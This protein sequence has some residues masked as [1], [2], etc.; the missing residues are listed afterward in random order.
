VRVRVPSYHQ[1]DSSFLLSSF[2]SLPLFLF[3][4]FFLLFSFF[5]ALSSLLFLLFS[6]LLFSSL[7]FSSLLFSSLLFSSL[8][9][10]SLLF[11]YLSSLIFPL[12]SFL[13]YLSS[14]IFPLLSFL[15]YLSSLI[16]LLL[17]FFSYLLTSVP[18][19]VPSISKMIPLNFDLAMPLAN[20]CKFIKS[21]GN[22]INME[23]INEIVY[24]VAIL[25]N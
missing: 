3:L 10:S 12:L 14:L 11:S 8:L 1:N 16:F 15:S 22:S 5:S 9:F 7:L 4:L 23:N 2:L 24:I 18:V 20:R 13:S 25:L 19:R 17:S 6:S 21:L